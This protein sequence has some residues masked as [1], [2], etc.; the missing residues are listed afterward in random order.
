MNQSVT[1]NATVAN[2]GSANASAFNVSFFAN[3][4]YNQM[5]TTSTIYH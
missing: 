3:N 2:I 1:I 5:T 4:A